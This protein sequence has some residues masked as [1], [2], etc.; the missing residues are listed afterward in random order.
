MSQPTIRR[1]VELRTQSFTPIHWAA[2]AIGGATGVVHAWL[3]TETGSVAFAFAA[4]VFVLAVLA[5]VYGLYRPVLYALGIPFTAGQV[6]LWFLSGMNF[7]AVGLLDKILQS[8]LVVLLAYLL[9]V[10]WWVPRR[11]DVEEARPSTR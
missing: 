11:G 3:Y 8:V 2:T 5:M 1:G 9:Y 10:D 4:V 6:V 7:F